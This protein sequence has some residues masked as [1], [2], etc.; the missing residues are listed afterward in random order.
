VLGLALED[1]GDLLAAWETGVC[2]AVRARLLPLVDERI[3]DVDRRIAELKAFS[4]SLHQA[5]TQ[6]SG[7]APAGGCG[8]DCGCVTA[9]ASTASTARTPA[10]RA[11][12][13]PVILSA[14][15]DAA[16][17]LEE[18]WRHEPVACT[19]TGEEIG[20][21]VTQW[22]ELLARCQARERIPDGLRLTFPSTAE[23][24]GNI[25]ALAA[26]EQQCCSFFDFSLQLSSSSLVLTVRAPQSAAD[27]LAELFGVA[28]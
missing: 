28:P 18:G 13:V 24:A 23:L 5:R 21:R 16:E 8:P 11:T 4:L 20:D 17:A 26:A 2:T 19:L 25:A 22:R 3:A 15:R 1:I 27:L 7:P 12:A 10:S 14:S 9:S 6:L